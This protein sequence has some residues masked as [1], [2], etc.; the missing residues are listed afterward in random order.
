MVFSHK[1]KFVITKFTQ[2]SPITQT[3]T[4][5]IGSFSK[6]IRKINGSDI[7]QFMN[8]SFIQSNGWNW[9][10]CTFITVRS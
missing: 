6:S 9:L 4:H 1:N 10:F 8:T 2:P 7:Y 3:D 5:F